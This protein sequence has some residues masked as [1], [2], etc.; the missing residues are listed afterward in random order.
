[1]GL[2]FLRLFLRHRPDWSDY[3]PLLTPIAALI[4]LKGPINGGR[5]MTILDDYSLSFFN[6][7]LL[8][9]PTTL[10]DGPSAQFPEV[11]FP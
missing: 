3:L 7:A 9:K 6:Q 10:L 11:T 1:M 8:G 4:G 2:N 5:V